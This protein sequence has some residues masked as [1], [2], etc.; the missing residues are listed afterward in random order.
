M[1]PDVA[2]AV[3]QNTEVTP[4]YARAMFSRQFRQATGQPVDMDGKTTSD[5]EYWAAS[6]RAIQRQAAEEAEDLRRR[7]GGR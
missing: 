6:E 4:A 2:G 3:N 1:E 5:R 7:R